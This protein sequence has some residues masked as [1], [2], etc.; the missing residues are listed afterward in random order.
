MGSCALLVAVRLVQP[1]DQERHFRGL[2]FTIG[3]QVRGSPVATT[4]NLFRPNRDPM[5][6]REVSTASS[7]VAD[8]NHVSGTLHFSPQ[9]TSPAPQG[10]CIGEDNLSEGRQRNLPLNQDLRAMLARRG[11]RQA[12]KERGLSLDP[13]TDVGTGTRT[14][15]VGWAWKHPLQRKHAL[16][17][18][19]ENCCFLVRKPVHQN[20][21]RGLQR[22]TDQPLSSVR[23]CTPSVYA[24]RILAVASFPAKASRQEA[25]AGDDVRGALRSS[26][27]EQAVGAEFTGQAAIR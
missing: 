17:R 12:L 6:R 2:V 5:I 24:R 23:V 22:E 19:D 18:E 10:L 20:F 16:E 15:A 3:N 13:S 27:V 26:H 9:E 4:S 14:A 21:P 7:G 11:Q 8:R 25:S 1:M